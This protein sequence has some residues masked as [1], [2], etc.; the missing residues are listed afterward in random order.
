[1]KKFING[2][3]VDLTAEEIAEMERLQTEMPEQEPTLEERLEAIEAAV[4][5]MLGVNMND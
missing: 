3:Y 4:L 2:K 5:E 1:M